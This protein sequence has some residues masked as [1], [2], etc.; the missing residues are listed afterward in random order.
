VVGGVLEGAIPA[1]TLSIWGFSTDHL[2]A[3]A[4]TT[5]I[6]SGVI[7]MLVTPESAKNF[8]ASGSV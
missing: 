2:T 8:D 6:Q 1:K 7:K 3:G 4:L 5:V